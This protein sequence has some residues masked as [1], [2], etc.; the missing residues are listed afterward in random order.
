MTKT[1]TAPSAAAT[2]SRQD[3]RLVEAL[4]LLLA[5]TYALT[6]LTQLAHWNVEGS[7]F[8]QLHDAFGAQYAS[9]FEAA[10]EI[11]ER[12]RALD[13][14]ATGGLE[15]M[16]R[17]AG[18]EEFKAPM[19]QKDYVVALIVAHEKVMDDAARARTLAEEF[20]DLETQDV[21]IGRIQAHQ[22]TVWMLK[23]F[24]KN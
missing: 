18:L 7:G 22:K 20:G 3:N 6:A 2:K 5:D 13:H 4:N 15:T 1:A 11:A 8:F 23:S 17:L 24:L 12:V 21:V 10:D 19:S 9:L 16:G 14:Y